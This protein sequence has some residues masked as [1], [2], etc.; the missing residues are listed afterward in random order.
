MTHAIAR[1]FLSLIFLFSATVC[2]QAAT[3]K[4]AVRALPAALGNPFTS[5]GQPASETWGAIFDA[6]TYIDGE[7]ILQPAL[8]LSWSATSDTE[9]QFQL[10]KGVEFQN[11]EAFNADAVMRTIEILQSDEGRG[12]FVSTEIA[13]IADVRATDPYTLIIKTKTPD[14]ILPTRLSLISIVAPQAWATLGAD[15]FAQKPVGTGPF[16]LMDWGGGSRASFTAFEKSW[17]A[18]RLQGLE[19]RIIPDTAARLQALLAGSV[20]IATGLSP[21][22]FALLPTDEF[23]TYTIETAAVFAIALRNVGNPQSPLQ[24][25][26]VRK[27]LNYAVNTQLISEGIFGGTVQPSSQGAQPPTFGYNPSL[28]PYGY[29]PAEARRLLTDAG[30]PN[31]FALNVDVL[32]GFAAADAALY[33]KVSDDLAQVGVKVTLRAIPYANWLQK[34]TSGAWGDTDGFSARWDSGAYYD[35]IRAIS[36]ASCDKPGPFFCAPEMMDAI[37]ESNAMFDPNLRREKLQSIMAQLKSDVAPAIWLVPANF[38][39]ASARTVTN[40]TG[41]EHGLRYNALMLTS[42]K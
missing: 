25:V 5:V 31:G 9:W 33:Q 40:F 14:A 16:K 27:A 20:E 36:A 19:F 23:N 15:K 2:G 8:A 39:I 24:D 7:G 17:R 41:G 3:L 12:F 26:R 4:V 13:N 42:G 28:K 6:L 29:N 10:R 35:T 11:G 18:P 38:Y 30:Y 37:R 1:A 22:D 34:Y 21:D 32:V